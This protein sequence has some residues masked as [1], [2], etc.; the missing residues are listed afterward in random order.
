MKN[1]GVEIIIGHRYAVRVQAE[2]EVDAV[3]KALTF[4]MDNEKELRTLELDGRV[5]SVEECK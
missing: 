5:E 2:G 3:N 1:Y 4:A